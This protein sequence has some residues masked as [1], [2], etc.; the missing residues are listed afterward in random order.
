MSRNNNNHLKKLRKIRDKLKEECEKFNLINEEIN[1]M[2]NEY[3]QINDNYNNYI[4]LINEGNNHT[5][6]ITNWEYYENLFVY[7]G[8][9]FFF[10]CVI[11][12]ISKRIP[13]NKIIIYIFESIYKLIDFFRKTK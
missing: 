12:V 1:A 9:Y 13:I 3:Q 2:H 11:Y 7:F 6:E 8:F 10:G 4:N 5:N